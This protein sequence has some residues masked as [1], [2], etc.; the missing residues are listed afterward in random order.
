MP[1]GYE[2]ALPELEKKLSGNVLNDL[3]Y[4]EETLAR[5]KS[6]FLVGKTLSLADVMLAFSVHFVLVR[7]LGARWD[8]KSYPGTKDWI[9]RL[10]KR[11]AWQVAV[12]QGEEGYT[13]DSLSRD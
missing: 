10:R 7:G 9:R 11:E 5:N 13:L 4:I 12:K 2:D 3:N 1:E 6:G 8:D